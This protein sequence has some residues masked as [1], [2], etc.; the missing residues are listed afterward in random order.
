MQST[1]YEKGFCYLPSYV[2]MCRFLTT[3]MIMDLLFHSS[4][5]K[6][7]IIHTYGQSRWAHVRMNF[8]KNNFSSIRIAEHIQ[9][10]AVKFG[11][12]DI[13]CNDIVFES[14]QSNLLKRNNEAVSLI[15]NASNSIG[16]ELH[17]VNHRVYACSPLSKENV[18]SYSGIR[19]A[20]GPKDGVGDMRLPAAG[21]GPGTSSLESD[22]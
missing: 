16:Q 14:G 10:R 6:C 5:L 7:R 11:Y 1:K 20:S 17:S 22:F 12:N 15:K 4:I 18:R 2:G 13:V 3:S 9:V 21:V 19:H 8:L